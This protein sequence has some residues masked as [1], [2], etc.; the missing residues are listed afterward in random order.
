[1]LCLTQRAS[2]MHRTFG[3]RI[4]GTSLRNKFNQRRSDGGEQ[5]QFG[6]LRA[7]SCNRAAKRSLHFVLVLF[8]RPWRR[9]RTEH[10]PM[11]SVNLAV[12]DVPFLRWRFQGRQLCWIVAAVALSLFQSTGRAQSVTAD[13][14]TCAAGRWWQGLKQRSCSGR[15]LGRGRN[16]QQLSCRCTCT[17]F[18]VR[19]L[20]SRRTDKVPHSLHSRPGS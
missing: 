18:L 7:F 20:E 1:M 8:L 6:L 15:R 13:S 5:S 12:D 16:T 3:I 19:T 2:G 17:L 14:V 9:L 4:L 11:T 10:P